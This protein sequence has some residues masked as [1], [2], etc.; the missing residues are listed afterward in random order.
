MKRAAFIAVIISLL[1]SACKTQQQAVSVNN[2]D[3]Y[4]TPSRQK[5]KPATPP[6]AN[7]DLTSALAADQTAVAHDSLKAKAAT[8]DYRPRRV[9]QRGR[10]NRR[11]G[12]Q[13]RR[14]KISAGNDRGRLSGLRGKG[15]V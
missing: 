7:Q 11:A 9:G 3:V 12:G 5:S 2:D 6:S 14:R 1:M 13:A 15:H 8:L 4:S 10:Q